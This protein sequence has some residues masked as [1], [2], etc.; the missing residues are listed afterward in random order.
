MRNASFLGRMEVIQHSAQEY[1]L[2]SQTSLGLSLDL[3]IY[4]G[5]CLVPQFPQGFRSIYRLSLVILLHTVVFSQN[6]VH[7]LAVAAYQVVITIICENQI[8]DRRLQENPIAN[9]VIT[10]K[11]FF[12]LYLYTHIILAWGS[13][14][15]F[16]LPVQLTGRE[17]V[18]QNLFVQLCNAWQDLAEVHCLLFY[19]V[20]SQFKINRVCVL[21]GKE[22]ERDL[23]P[24]SSGYYGKTIW[25]SQ[26]YCG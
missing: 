25:N 9:M 7:C 26:C 5:K 11:G 8:H 22:D 1:K 3:T 20:F 4:W 24:K 2:K 14:W 18:A 6:S 15:N 16:F 13:D 21:V 12:Q 17:F 23:A 19:L 10:L